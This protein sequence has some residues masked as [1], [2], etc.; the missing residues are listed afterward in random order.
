[1]IS[2]GENMPDLLIRNLDSS[3]INSLKLLA[4]KHHRSLQGELKCIIETATKVSFADAAKISAAWQQ[5]LSG[6]A[7]SD[8]ASLVRED[9][10]TR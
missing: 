8:S 7:F 2:K 5:R 1:M 4:K 10:D 9:R 3:T 6:G